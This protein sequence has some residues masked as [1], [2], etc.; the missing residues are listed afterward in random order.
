MASEA[1]KKCD[2]IGCPNPGVQMYQIVPATNIW[3][4]SICLY[5]ETKAVEPQLHYVSHPRPGLDSRDR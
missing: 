4:C 3:L 5:L 2:S 1:A